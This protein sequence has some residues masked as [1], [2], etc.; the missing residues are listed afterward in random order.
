VVDEHKSAGRRAAQLD[1]A[2]QV[3]PLSPALPLSAREQL[4]AMLFAD[5]H[6]TAQIA[7]ALGLADNTVRS[8]LST[9]RRKYKNAGRDASHK[10]QLRDRLV[11]DGHLTEPRPPNY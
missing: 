5:G 8:Y 6:T 11:E 3:L 2:I 4:V 10:L 7:R 1:Q 9:V